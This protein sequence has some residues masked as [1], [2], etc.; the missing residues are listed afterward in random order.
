MGHRTYTSGRSNR[1][2]SRRTRSGAGRHNR[3][4]VDLTRPK[5]AVRICLGCNHPFR[6][7]GPWNRICDRCHEENQGKQEPVIYPV[8]REYRDVLLDA[9]DFWGA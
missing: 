6:S 8:P 9:D 3:K 5:A 1:R 7:H 2:G 4:K